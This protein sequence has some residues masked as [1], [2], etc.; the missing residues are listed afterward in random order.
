M[1]RIFG[2]GGKT[3]KEI[4]T[5]RCCYIDIG[6]V[7]SVNFGT[8]NLI[9]GEENRGVSLN[10]CLEVFNTYGSGKYLYGIGR[11]AEVYKVAVVYIS[12]NFKG[13]FTGSIKT[14]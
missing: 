13:V 8:L 7:N 3:F 5:F 6:A 14:C 9:P 12:S 4:L 1:E 10:F 2:S 11:C